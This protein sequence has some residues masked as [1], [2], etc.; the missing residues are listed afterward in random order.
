MAEFG[1]FYNSYLNF[2]AID[3]SNRVRSVRV[4]R[5]VQAQDDTVMGDTGRSEAAGL[6]ADT[7][8]AEFNQEFG[9]SLLDATI[10]GKLGIGQSAAI[11]VRPSN[12]AVATTN[13]KWSGT[14][15]VRSYEPVAGAVGDQA[16]ARATF[17]GPLTRATA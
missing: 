17:F 8:E 2:S 11:E 13:P 9:T 15:I 1:I 16:I 10:S 3:L 14:V 6:I 5:E 12:A 4:S 7:I